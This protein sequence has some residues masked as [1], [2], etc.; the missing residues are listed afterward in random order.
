MTAQIDRRVAVDRARSF[1]YFRI[2]KAANSTVAATL[3]PSPAREVSSDIAKRSFSRASSLTYREVR[4]LAERFFLFT[5]VRDPYSRLASAYLDKVKKDKARRQI[6]A[7][8]KCADPQRITFLEFCRFLAEGGINV[9][10][11][12]YRQSDLIPCGVDKLHYVGRVESLAHDMRQIASRIGE[13]TGPIRNIVWHGTGASSK[14][15]EL[16][17]SETFE[18]VQHLYAVDFAA[19]GYPIEP[20]WASEWVDHSP[21]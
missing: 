12:W 9:N 8:Y 16:Y 5:V 19:F 13:G 6:V 11:H 14:L 2:P 15:R 1:I 3:H 18:I 21:E 4:E 17:C 20:A 7:R 10:P